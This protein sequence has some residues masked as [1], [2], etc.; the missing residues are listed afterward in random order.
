MIN[1]GILSKLQK[2][3]EIEADTY[4]GSY[5]LVNEIVR[6]YASMNDYS[7]CDYH[8]VN[9]IYLMAI[10][11]WKLNVEKKKEYVELSNLPYYEKRRL[12]GVL[13]IVWDKACRGGYKH[14]NGD[15]PTIGMFGTGFYSFE[16]NLSNED[17]RR[18]ISMLIDI[19]GML[20]DD[21]IFDRAE[22]VLA[23]NIKG[24][25]AASVSVILHCLK[26]Y[27]FP[28]LNSNAGKGTIFDAIG[29]EVSK[30]SSISRYIDNCRI[31]KSFRDEYLP[32]KNYRVLDI[33]ARD[34]SPQEEWYPTL[35]E[36][37]PGISSDQW[38]ELLTNPDIIGPIWGRIL[39]MF[40]VENNGVS[41]TYLANKYGGSAQSISGSISQMLT[42]I[43]KKIQCPLYSIDSEEKYWPI[44]FQYRDAKKSEIGHRLWKLRDELLDAISETDIEK[45]LTKEED[46]VTSINE[47]SKN[48]ILYGPPGTGKTYNTVVY[49]VSIIEE[50]AIEEVRGEASIDY[51]GVKSRY[52]EYLSKGR[53]AFTTFHQSYG[54][55]EFIEGIKPIM[56]EDESIGYKIESGVFKEFCDRASIPSSQSVSDYGLNKEPNV[57]KVSLGGTHENPVRAD[58][59]QNDHI[60]IGYDEFGA[61]IADRIDELPRGKNVLNAFVNKMRIG[62]IVLSCYTSTQ[63]DAIGVITGDYEWDE[64]YIEYKRTRTVKWLVKDIREDIVELNNG[65]SMTLSTVYW[66]S[67]PIR[68]ILNIVEKYSKHKSTPVYSNKDKY[69]FII[70]EINRGNISKIFGEL[71]TLIEESKRMGENEYISVKLPYSHATFGVPNNVYI[72]GTMNTA[73]RSIAIMDTA[74]RRRFSF[75][76]ML[77]DSDVLRSIGADIVSDNGVKLNVADMLDVINERITFLYDREHTIGHAFFTP[78]RDNPSVNTLAAIFEKSIIPLLQEYFYEDYSKIQLVLGDDGKN[79]PDKKQYQFIR[80]EEMNPYSI[81]ISAP[82]LETSIKY[83][84]QKEAFYN[85]NSYKLIDSRL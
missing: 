23:E 30:L 9:A 46:D 43:Y 39:A 2:L 32:Y 55:E 14:R 7:M 78:L 58:C 16:R 81:F 15:K 45:Y 50:K 24:M 57:W 73:D 6:S 51:S 5:E 84:I 60:R 66:M 77:P 3:S 54:Y 82:E 67:I 29:L 20:D 27:T 61:D 42:T 53:I 47:I 69:V 26:P 25:G 72:L 38:Y 44:A 56:S 35:D 11:T 59:L 83:S 48:T 62:D 36:Y 21:I 33:A 74:L 40:Y 64:N 12:S 76:E 34:I 52:D 28:I 18:F 65:C 71:I 22:S 68:E 80:N 31:I 41:C 13:D 1:E 10:G 19:S 17:A 8:D 4:D 85:I 49:A 70:D 63:I 79:D 37:D 75:V